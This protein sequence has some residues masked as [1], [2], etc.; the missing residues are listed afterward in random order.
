MNFN[1]K[2]RGLSILLFVCLIHTI[3][4]Y[5]VHADD[6]KTI[7]SK[8]FVVLSNGD[9]LETIIYEENNIKQ[10]DLNKRL[11]IDK[12]AVTRILKT[13]E[14]K[15]FIIKKTAKENKRNHVLSL[16]SKGKELYPKIKDVIKETTEMMIKDIDQN[17]LILLEELLLKMKMNLEDTYEKW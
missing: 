10:E 15:R 2:K 12:S 6:S 11:Q 5:N 17:E 14:D 13:L 4:L 16:T 7:I 8:E 9:C 3:F 1:T